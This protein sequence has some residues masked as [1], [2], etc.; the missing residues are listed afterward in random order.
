MIQYFLCHALD[1]SVSEPSSVSPRL[2]FPV[3]LDGPAGTSSDIWYF[4]QESV[5]TVTTVGVL[6]WTT[7]NNSMCH[8]NIVF[9]N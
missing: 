3:V 7:I 4:V 6:L 5:A 2:S 1:S 8:I 9:S